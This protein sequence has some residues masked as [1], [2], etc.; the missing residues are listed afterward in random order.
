MDLEEKVLLIRMRIE[1]FKKKFET[2]LKK[3]KNTKKIF[4]FKQEGKNNG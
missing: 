2:E 4:T 1:R 3:V